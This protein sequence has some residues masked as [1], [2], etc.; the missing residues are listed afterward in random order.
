MKLFSFKCITLQQHLFIFQL[1]KQNDVFTQCAITSL[2]SNSNVVKLLY[3][4]N[5]SVNIT[6]VLKEDYFSV[7]V[8]C[9]SPD[10][11]Y[12][13]KREKITTTTHL[14]LIN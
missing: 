2:A 1:F 6:R 8:V 3:F 11:K 14:V 10:E 5:D 7:S 9:A 12:L 13:M 4:S